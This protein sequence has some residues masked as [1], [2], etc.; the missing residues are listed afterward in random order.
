MA[1]MW[2]LSDWEFKTTMINMLRALIY[3]VDS[4]QGQM[5]NIS[6]NIEIIRTKKKC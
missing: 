4:R 2:E 6:R 5:G 1:G 3:E